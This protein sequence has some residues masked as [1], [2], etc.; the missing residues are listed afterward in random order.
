M[1]AL[2]FDLVTRLV[3]IGE[4]DLGSHTR[5]GLVHTRMA[6]RLMSCCVL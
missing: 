3:H 1:D 5:K 2:G 6:R 4:F